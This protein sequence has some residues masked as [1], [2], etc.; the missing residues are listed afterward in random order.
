M[1]GE[2]VVAASNDFTITVKVLPQVKQA[3]RAALL[4]RGTK[5]RMVMIRM[6]VSAVMLAIKDHAAAVSCLIIDEEYSGYE[7]VIKA[8]LLDRIRALGVEF[9]KENIAISRVGKQ[10]PAHRAAIMVTRREVKADMQPTV[11]ELLKFC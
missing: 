8:L 11:E 3:V 9:P 10:S 2:T 1:S 6:F 5:L 7:A 4:A